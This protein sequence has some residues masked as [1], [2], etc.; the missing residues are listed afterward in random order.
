M[1]SKELGNFFAWPAVIAEDVAQVATGFDGGVLS[2]LGE[3][4]LFLARGFR[5]E[6][7]RYI[8]VARV[9]LVIAIPAAE[10]NDGTHCVC[11]GLSIC[12]VRALEEFG[13]DLQSTLLSDAGIL[14]GLSRIDA[15]DLV[16]DCASS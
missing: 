10:E 15:V 4:L 13:K 3:P 8:D 12:L 2:A 1:V 9:S 5:N 14:L 11:E 16:F 7:D 6:L